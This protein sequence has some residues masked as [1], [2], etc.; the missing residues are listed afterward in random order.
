MK[1]CPL[2]GSEVNEP[3]LAQVCPAC[4]CWIETEFEYVTYGENSDAQNDFHP[5][6]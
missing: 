3:P 4:G 5:E 6:V 2:C 1:V